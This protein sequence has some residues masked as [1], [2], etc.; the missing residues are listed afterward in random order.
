MVAGTWNIKFPG[1]IKEDLVFD[2]I[3]HVHLWVPDT[4]FSFYPVLAVHCTS[5]NF[6]PVKNLLK[7]T[8]IT[9]FFYLPCAIRTFSMS[10]Y[11]PLELKPRDCMA[12]LQT[13]W[14]LPLLHHWEL[15]MDWMRL[16]AV[17]CRETKKTQ[18]DE[19]HFCLSVKIRLMNTPTHLYVVKPRWLMI[20][21][22]RVLTLRGKST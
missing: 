3:V 11:A 12:V 8:E 16:I 9:R 15:I 6:L 4:P 22:P 2:H 21:L 18:S 1:R 17:A 7:I 19:K 14:F 13:L 5:L 20:D 10:L